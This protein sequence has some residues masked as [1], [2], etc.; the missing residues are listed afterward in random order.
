[1]HYFSLLLCFASFAFV[2][3]FRWLKNCVF[4]RFFG[5]FSAFLLLSV[6]SSANVQKRVILSV[7]VAQF[8][9]TP[10]TPYRP[11]PTPRLPFRI[12][13]FYFFSFL[14]PMLSAASPKIFF[15]IFLFFY[16][17]RIAMLFDHL[18]DHLLFLFD[19]MRRVNLAHY[20]LNLKS[21][22]SGATTSSERP[23]PRD[24]TTE[25]VVTSDVWQKTCG[26]RDKNG[27]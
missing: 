10:P 25:T 9:E 1:M 8:F 19:H 20:F 22:R 18:F 6:C 23:L 15:H 26:R 17:Q 12:I 3:C 5:R 2:C 4:G 21:W 27:R 11:P 13:F 24:A 7:F 14:P 16:F